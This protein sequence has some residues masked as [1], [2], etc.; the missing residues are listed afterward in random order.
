M[1]LRL[2]KPDSD[3]T[4]ADRRLAMGQAVRATR[5][6]IRTLWAT[7]STDEERAFVIRTLTTAADELR[8]RMDGK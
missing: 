7:A 3:I 8:L 5:K 4:E 2:V 6:A 1:T